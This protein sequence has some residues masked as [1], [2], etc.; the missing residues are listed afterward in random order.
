VIVVLDSCALIAFFRNEEGSAVVLDLLNKAKES[1]IE[2]LVHR[3]TIFEVFYDTLRTSGSE[4]ASLILQDITNFPLRV[5]ND[6][7]DE[8]LVAHGYFKIHYRLS[9]A[10]CFVL[11]LA[12]LKGASVVTTDHHEFDAVEKAGACSFLWLR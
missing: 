2:V 1:G 4:Y 11:S 7:S 9:F 8:I 5:I 6:L 12:Q 10:D 3:V